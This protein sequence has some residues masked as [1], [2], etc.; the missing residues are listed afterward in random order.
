MYDRLHRYRLDGY[1]IL[2][3]SVCFLEVKDT[4]S[5]TTSHWLTPISFPTDTSK[6]REIHLIVNVVVNVE[7][8]KHV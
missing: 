6:Y 5:L 3:F 1:F 4:Y 8:L 2:T 7:K